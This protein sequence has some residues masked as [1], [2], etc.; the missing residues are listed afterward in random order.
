MRESADVSI[1]NGY[2]STSRVEQAPTTAD[3]TQLPRTSPPRSAA[4]GDPILVEAAA[5]RSVGWGRRVRVELVA[6]TADALLLARARAGLPHPGRPEG[7]GSDTVGWPVNFCAGCGRHVRA[8]P[9]NRHS[10]R[11]TTASGGGC[12]GAA[13]D[14][15]RAKGDPSPRR[16]HHQEH[17][18]RRHQPGRLGGARSAAV[19]GD[20]TAEMESFAAYHPAETTRPIS[21][22]LATEVEVARPAGASMGGDLGRAPSRPSLARRPGS[23]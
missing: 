20:P 11:C 4:T 5:L 15:D 10:A 19:T 22:A 14:G 16:L 21:Q 13:T 7:R 23:V 2:R 3:P 1:E 9:A 17:R 8:A 12:S 18:Q 6:A